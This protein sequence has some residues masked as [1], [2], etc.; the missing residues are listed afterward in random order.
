MLVLAALIVIIGISW[1][2]WE[3]RRAALPG[4]YH[5]DGVWG[6]STLVLRSDHTFTQNVTFMEYDEP[7]VAPY[8]RHVTASK[9]IT[10]TWEENGRSW[11]DQELTFKPFISLLRLDQGKTYQIFPASFGLVALTGPGIEIDISRGIVYRKT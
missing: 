3:T 1:A 8:P 10:G 6:T 2:T 5:T 11:F 4:V 9:S 7:S